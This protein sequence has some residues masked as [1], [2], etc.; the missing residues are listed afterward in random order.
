MKKSLIVLPLLIISIIPISSRA[1]VL[2]DAVVQISAPGVTHEQKITIL[3]SVLA[4]LTLKLELALE[5]HEQKNRDSSEDQR[6]VTFL[7]D[8]QSAFDQGNIDE[9]ENYM[10]KRAKKEVN[11]TQENLEM[12]AHLAQ[13]FF[14]DTY[15]YFTENDS[16]LVASA[17]ITEVKVYE[18]VSFEK[19]TL[20]FIKGDD[21]ALK[22]DRVMLKSFGSTLFNTGLTYEETKT[23]YTKRLEDSDGDGILDV[24]EECRD[25]FDNIK[26][27]CV[28]TDPY[29]KDSDGDGIWDGY[30]L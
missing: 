24:D 18:G 29:S 2:S 7:N 26:E 13:T 9:I 25:I 6:V 4:Q 23:K 8:L 22:L 17:D 30:E 14:S 28:P 19:N 27:G 20:L 3:Q 12:T 15:V 1:S 11:V 21:G 5:K 10:T 16:Y